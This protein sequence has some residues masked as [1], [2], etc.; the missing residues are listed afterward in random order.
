MPLASELRPELSVRE[1]HRRFSSDVCVDARE[2]DGCP[3]VV[4]P[5]LASVLQVSDVRTHTS[6]SMRRRIRVRVRGGGSVGDGRPEVRPGQ[7]R[8]RCGEMLHINECLDP[9]ALLSH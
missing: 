9:V 7:G 1:A 3:R 5:V 4:L 2:R 6:L 8:E